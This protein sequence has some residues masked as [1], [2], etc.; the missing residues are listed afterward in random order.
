LAPARVKIKS[1][2]IRHIP[3]CIVGDNSDVVPYLVLVRIAFERI[4]RGA[5]RDVL[6]PGNTA[7]RAKGIEQ[8]RIG[9]VR[10]VPCVVPDSIQP[11]IRRDCKRAEPVPLD[12]RIGIV[13]DPVWR[14]EG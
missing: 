12:L 1:G 4:K 11:P 14:A 13:I 2:G 6:R 9:V 3:A 10:R 5:D 7:V 8:L